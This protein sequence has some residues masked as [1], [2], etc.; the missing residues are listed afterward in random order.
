M[1]LKVNHEE[2]KFKPKKINRIIMLNIL[3]RSI[4]KL[5]NLFGYN[6]II[7]IINSNANFETNFV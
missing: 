3:I 6:I 4:Q 7:S 2:V 5:V 1:W